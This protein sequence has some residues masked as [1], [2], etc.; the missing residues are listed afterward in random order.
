M[1]QSVEPVKDNL[2]RIETSSGGGGSRNENP[3]S[4]SAQRQTHSGAVVSLCFNNS[5]HSS[6]VVI[7]VSHGNVYL[8]IRFRFHPG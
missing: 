2:P 5:V 1:M 7:F 8:I 3:A 6:Q 4:L